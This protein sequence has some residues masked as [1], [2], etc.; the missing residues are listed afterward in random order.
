MAQQAEQQAEQQ[1]HA[2]RRKVGETDHHPL[3]HSRDT[4]CPLCFDCPATQWETEALCEK[5]KEQLT[6]RG[7]IAIQLP[8]KDTLYLYSRPITTTLE[9]LRNPADYPHLNTLA[10]VLRP[11]SSAPGLLQVVM[12]ATHT[13]H[14]GTLA[15]QAAERLW[16][17]VRLLK[18]EEDKENQFPLGAYELFSSLI[19]RLCHST[20][21]HAQRYSH[22]LQDA[23]PPSSASSASFAIAHTCQ[24]LADGTQAG[25]ETWLEKRLW[26]A[27]AS[28]FQGLRWILEKPLWS[29]FLFDAT[30][31]LWW[32]G[33]QKLDAGYIT[34]TL[35]RVLTQPKKR[36]GKIRQPVSARVSLVI[37][38]PDIEGPPDENMAGWEWYIPHTLL[39]NV[40][41]F[42][43]APSLEVQSVR[44]IDDYNSDEDDE[45]QA[46]RIDKNWS[47]VLCALLEQ[48]RGATSLEATGS[49]VDGRR[50]T[51]S[52][53][54]ESACSNVRLALW[55]MR[56]LQIHWETPL[57]VP[58]ARTIEVL[59]PWYLEKVVLCP[60]ATLA[61]TDGELRLILNTL[62]R[63]HHDIEEDEAGLPLTDA[64]QGLQLIHDNE[65]AALSDVVITI[66][67]MRAPED[68]KDR[69]LYLQLENFRAR[70][71]TL[72]GTDGL[73][74]E[75]S[76][77]G[78]QRRVRYRV[79][80]M[81]GM[82]FENL[83]SG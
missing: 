33:E 55:N 40:T 65:G 10:K 27:L 13:N 66:C 8:A 78:N 72:Q 7:F 14:A 50:V 56:E 53:P 16:T 5:S 1:G 18:K 60:A 52:Y 17:F 28:D 4:H 45:D 77:V 32:W 39:W 51:V 57:T 42:H 58:E 44:V 47:K 76:S 23:S 64:K 37:N 67:S 68:H 75:T 3:R 12:V 15:E 2:K 48:H 70:S 35:S 74:A 62:L 82:K 41:H 54:L 79:V 36:Q 25:L 22:Q 71:V 26:K 31:L 9:D 80:N 63:D 19:T 69:P 59:V 20:K 30:R 6:T 83:R 81:P 29:Q 21:W 61:D 24:R 38:E 49:L 34:H 43:P 46:P 11:S 73:P